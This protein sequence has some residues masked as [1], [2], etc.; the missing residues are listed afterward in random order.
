MKFTT[1]LFGIALAP[2]ADQST[3]PTF[4]ESKNRCTSYIERTAQQ[5]IAEYQ[6]GRRD[7]DCTKMLNARRLRRPRNPER[8]FAGADLSNASFRGSKLKYTSWDE[9][10]VQGTDFSYANLSESQLGMNAWLNSDG[11]RTNFTG[12]KLRCAT[13][14][15][16]FDY[17]DFTRANFR[18]N[19]EISH[20]S[21][22]HGEFSYAILVGSRFSD[23]TWFPD[24]ENLVCV[25]MTEKDV[26]RLERNKY[27]SQAPKVRDGQNLCQN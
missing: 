4:D 16:K 15:G 25:E 18:C 19:G 5:I 22:N 13:L 21:I 24:P 27:Q 2:K 20:T 1:A 8:N 11:G 7:F 3:I 10:E 9:A 14:D 26:L 17:A 23:N 6:L 12:A